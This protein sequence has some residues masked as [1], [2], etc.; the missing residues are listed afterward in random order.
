MQ[1]NPALRARAVEHSAREKRRRA[2][3]TAGSCYRL[4]EARQSRTSYVQRWTRSGWLRSRGAV[5]AVPIGW[6]T[7]AVIVTVL[8]VLA[9]GVHADLKP[10]CSIRCRPGY[11]RGV[12]GLS[13]SGFAFGKR[14]L[15]QKRDGLKFRPPLVLHLILT[16]E[17]SRCTVYFCQCDV[18]CGTC[19][20]IITFK[21]RVTGSTGQIGTK[22]RA[23]SDTTPTPVD[24]PQNGDIRTATTTAG[25]TLESPAR[26]SPVPHRH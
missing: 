16:T 6:S 23:P 24:P 8:T 2:V 9:I 18:N 4:H 22:N 7:T 5:A 10:L 11:R 12:L 13:R 17:C 19:S 20:P 26:E 15:P 3:V 21:I 25:L 1:L 14:R